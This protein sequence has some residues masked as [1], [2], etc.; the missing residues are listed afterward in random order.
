VLSTFQWLNNL[1]AS[2]AIRES[3]WMSPIVNVAHLAALVMF[4]GAVLIVDLKLVGNDEGT[5]VDAIARGAHPWLVRGF[6]LLF[7]TGVP[8]LIS[9]AL[10][11]YYS[12][13]FW[14]KMVVM[15]LALIFTF[16]VRKRVTLAAP[17]AVTAGTRKLVGAVSIALWAA[18]AIPARLIGLFT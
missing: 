1:P 15:V 3:I 4:V 6:V 12:V 18:V 5:P 9:N 14:F 13:F 7:I 2:I 16:T 11:E 10:R 17:G 8:Q